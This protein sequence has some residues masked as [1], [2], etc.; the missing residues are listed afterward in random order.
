MKKSLRNLLVLLAIL[1]LGG[2]IYFVA[3]FFK[4][5]ETFVSN[6]PNL[7]SNENFTRNE[8][9]VSIFKNIS[10]E[11]AHKYGI[12]QET[13]NAMMKVFNNNEPPAKL[14]EIFKNRLEEASAIVKLMNANK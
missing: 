14:V 2:V 12:S 9:N 13:Y 7:N 11:E 4:K 3:S 5:N 1:V 8:K 6:R 10:S